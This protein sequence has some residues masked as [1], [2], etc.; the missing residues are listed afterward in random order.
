M[1]ATYIHVSTIY[2]CLAPIGI[3]WNFAVLWSQMSASMYIPFR[4][5]TNFYSWNEAPVGAHVYLWCIKILIDIL[6]H[7]RDM[8]NYL[9]HYKLLSHEWF[10]IIN[11]D[12]SLC[13][14]IIPF[15]PSYYNN[16]KVLFHALNKSPNPKINCCPTHVKLYTTWLDKFIQRIFMC[17]TSQ[18]GL[19]VA[20]QQ[21][22]LDSV[23]TCTC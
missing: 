10:N 14:Q 3:Q 8:P 17:E 7:S 6:N 16:K 11:G 9:M 21:N 13:W 1:V 5:T 22:C 2:I 12:K 15:L 18:Q 20:Y 19:I 4:H 23:N